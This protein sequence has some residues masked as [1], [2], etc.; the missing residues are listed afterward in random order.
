MLNARLQILPALLVLGTALWCGPS[1]AQA[2]NPRLRET[3]IEL[4][5]AADADF[6]QVEVRSLE[7]SEAKSYNVGAA[8]ARLKVKLPPG[9][10]A[11]RTRSLNT[12]GIVGPW[13]D[14]QLFAV[15]EKMAGK[16]AG[17]IE[18]PPAKPAPIP[19]PPPVLTPP[20]L[21]APMPPRKKSAPY[22][23]KT[24]IGDAY[25]PSAPP[26][27]VP[28]VAPPAASPLPAEKVELPELA[29]PQ[30]IPK[31]P[32]PDV[33]LIAP[34]IG[35]VIDPT[36]DLDTPVR[37]AW[38][39]EPKAGSYVLYIYDGEGQV[40]AN[41]KSTDTRTVVNL[42]HNMNYRWN[43]VALWPGQDPLLLPARPKS[44]WPFF[45]KDYVYMKLAASEEPKHIYGWGRYILSNADYVG[46]N[47]D[48]NSTVKQKIYAGQGEGA[49]GYWMRRSHFGWLAHGGLSGFRVDK[50]YFYLDG[51]VHFGHRKIFEEGGRLRNWIGLTYHEA[52]EV[53]RNAYS[54]PSPIDF[55]RVRNLGPQYQISYMN[56]FLGS[57]YGYHLFATIYRGQWDAGTPNHL[58]QIPQFTFTSGLFLTWREND[59]RKW[60]MGYTFKQENVR[61]KSTSSL[62]QYNTSS[63]TG[64]YFSLSME[65][66]LAEH[67]R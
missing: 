18:A 55:H 44:A 14:W 42:P 24:P 63:L 12:Q 1:S 57:E 45:V 15:K 38:T 40:F 8:N 33:V 46:R 30:D 7:E 19:A 65:F 41:Y 36:D 2:E 9:D 22:V 6:Y 16:T 25:A 66:G 21:A 48:W 61:Y 28:Y 67:Y 17:G 3:V 23:N 43:V 37:F 50:S 52:P 26:E 31:E 20:T 32:L 4:D 58:E 64:H 5:P 47:G 62:N 27:I 10:Y 54:N 53:L 56:D 49:L 29:Q 39:R 13:G 34:Q 35:K 11:L 60:M 59:D 51:G